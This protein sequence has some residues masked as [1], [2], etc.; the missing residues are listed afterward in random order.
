LISS[1]PPNRGFEAS[2][3]PHLDT[4]N[5]YFDSGRIVGYLAIGNEDSMPAR[6]AEPRTYHHGDLRAALL[7]AATE[8]LAEHGVEG[9]TL[10]SCA[11][12]AGVSHAAP[13]HHFGDVT[14]LLT[15]VAIDAF[16]RLAA[17]IRLQTGKVEQKASI[18]HPIAVA[19]GYVLFALESPAEATLMF[20]TEKLDPARPGFRAA[21]AEAFGPTA[22]AVGAF[23]GS[24]DP[25]ADP[26]LVRRI[27]SLW[28]LSQGLATLLISG[29]LGPLPQGEKTIRALLPDM[30][31]ELF[32]VRPA[33]NPKDLAFIAKTAAAQRA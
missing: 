11:R 30:V 12:R 22:A 14:G 2:L 32:G 3:A 9:F 7:R 18:E 21:S 13:A 10:R 26:I 29:Q 19:V 33:D 15:E 24:A 5:I 4:V 27:L 16:H 8:E 28:S 25:M 6:K 31:R 23:F 17:S 20:R 1:L